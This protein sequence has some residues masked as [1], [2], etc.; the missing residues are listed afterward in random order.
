MSDLPLLRARGRLANADAFLRRA[1]DMGLSAWVA[2]A[3]AALST[4][5]LILSGIGHLIGW[6][7]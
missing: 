2:D 1:T 4:A 7:S 6:W 5:G 3:L